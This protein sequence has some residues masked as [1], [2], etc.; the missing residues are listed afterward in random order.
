MNNTTEY[1]KLVE[2]CGEDAANSLL[3]RLDIDKQIFALKK[4][5]EALEEELKKSFSVNLSW[6]DI[7]VAI[8]AGVLCGVMNDCLSL[9]FQSTEI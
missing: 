9:M 3:H 1:L 2:F 7:I 8:S 6:A 5:Q 4:E